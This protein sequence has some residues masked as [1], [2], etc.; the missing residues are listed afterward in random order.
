MTYRFC[1][2]CMADIGKGRNRE[3][4]LTVM[5]TMAR[6]SMYPCKYFKP[7]CGTVVNK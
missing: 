1:K 6:L 5:K 2:Q 4:K 3:A 7:E